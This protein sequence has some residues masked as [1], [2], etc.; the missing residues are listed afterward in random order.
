M[1]NQYILSILFQVLFVSIGYNQTEKLEVSVD[2]R[3]ENYHVL[4]SYGDDFLLAGGHQICNY[5]FVERLNQD[6]ERKWFVSYFGYSTITH[7]GILPDSSI[8]FAYKSC[9]GEL[10]EIDMGIDVVKLNADG[11]ENKHVS[12]NMPYAALSY[13]MVGDSI[14][15][16][17]GNDSIWVFD[18][19]LDMQYRFKYNTP[20][21]S[22]FTI[23]DK[24]YIG[25]IINNRIRF[26]DGAFQNDFDMP[27][28][29]GLKIYNSDT[30]VFLYDTSL[31]MRYD[32]VLRSFRTMQM[33]NGI[34]VRTL[35]QQGDNLLL[36]A[37]AGI[38]FN[39]LM[40]LHVD[41]GMMEQINAIQKSLVSWENVIT[42]D[43]N[44]F[45]TGKMHQ[46]E[47]D[48]YSIDI[49]A[50]FL[51]RAPEQKTIERPE[52]DLSIQAID[53]IQIPILE[54][55]HTVGNTNVFAPLTRD[56]GSIEIVFQNLGADTITEFELAGQGSFIMYCGDS[57]IVKEFKDMKIPPGEIFKDTLMWR[58]D[59][60]YYFAV[61]EVPMLDF[62]FFTL[63]NNKFD[64][65]PSNDSVCDWMQFLVPTHE[66]DISDQFK[67]YPNPAA[68]QIT[69]Q[70]ESHG[71]F[72]IELI[73][74]LGQV[75]YKGKVQNVDT[76]HWE[77]TNEPPGMYH[78]KMKSDKGTGTFNL[79]LQ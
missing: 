62:C 25:M 39:V 60:E 9:C 2:N 58:P 45:Y 44:N 56:S 51:Y 21:S 69:I 59:F 66:P 76:Y 38:D 42:L 14:F 5:P 79:V 29:P 35:R 70:Y 54:L 13:G 3:Y 34:Q 15:V 43:G 67:V 20:F 65:D 47:L 37:T 24:G 7:V 31:L 26:F 49:D 64:K 17:S 68:E 50:P 11:T 63:L 6:L 40:R 10:P 27:T 41:G 57:R 36:G 18:T 22:L 71:A 12:L 55:T 46:P 28:T 4:E 30:D 32:D 23:N 73:N 48:I 77:R 16:V 74:S 19:D 75:V 78:L 8:L 52:S 33:V 72:T 53:F 61:G 1:Q